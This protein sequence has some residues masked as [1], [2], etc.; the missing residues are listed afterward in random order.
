MSLHRFSGAAQESE[1]SLSVIHDRFSSSRDL[2]LAAIFHAGLKYGR[3]NQLTGYRLLAA[4]P[5]D[6]NRLQMGLWPSLIDRVYNTGHQARL[7][8]SINEAG[9]ADFTAS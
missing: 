2:L 5:L 6:V 9:Y 8:L 1:L 3:T 4:P 7:T